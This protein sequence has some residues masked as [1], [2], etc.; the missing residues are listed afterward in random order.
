MVNHLGSRDSILNQFLSEI[1]D[2]ELQKDSLR[3]RRNME[4]IGEIF[5]YEISRTLTYEV[6]EVTT[7]LGIANVPVLS[8][9]PLLVTVLRAGLPF[10][11]G[12]LNYFDRSENAFISAYRKA[13]GDMTFTAK[14][15]Y[16]SL[17]EVEGKTVILCD[18]MLA[19]GTS[20][21]RAYKEILYRG[22]PK[23]THIAC[24]LASIEGVE[25][26]KKNIPEED[27]TLWVGAVDDEL[28]A[29]AYIVPGL[30]D[31][32]DLAFGTRH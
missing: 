6:K 24:V 10:H 9:S 16:I 29:Q 7:S 23:H 5:A 13:H 20:M 11:A 26:L 12:F 31:A 25:V 15:E 30:G 32:G 3:F 4:R 27:F 14:I 8:P 1:R 17:H 22:K 21:M 18:P 2:A 28:T 19:T